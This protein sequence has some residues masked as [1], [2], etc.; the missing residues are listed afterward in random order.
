MQG[1]FNGTIRLLEC[2]I[3]PVYV[4]DSKPPTL[5]SGELAKIIDRQRMAQQKLVEA[6]ETGNQEDDA[7][8]AKQTIIVT[9]F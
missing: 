6:Q 2:G 4:F 9:Q 7:K 5:K 8:F 3:R 1:I